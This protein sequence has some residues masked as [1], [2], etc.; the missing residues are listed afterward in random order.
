MFD[1]EEEVY[2]KHCYNKMSQEKGYQQS[3][4]TTSIKGSGEE[5]CPRCKGKVFEAE[6]MKTRKFLFHKNCFS[7][8]NCKHHL[9]YSTLHESKDGEAYC[10]MCYINIFFTSGKNSFMEPKSIPAMEGDQACIRCNCKVFDTEKVMS[11]H[12]IYHLA[13]L[14]C[15]NCATSLSQA[16]FYAGPEKGIYCRNCYD[17]I[18][19]RRARSRSRGPLNLT[20]FQAEENDENRCMGCGGKI[21]EAEKFATCFGA[22]H[23]PCFRCSKCSK[24]LHTSAE[25]ACSRNGQV[26]CRQCYGREKSKSVVA[27]NDENLIYAKSISESHIIQAE[28]GDPFGC[29]RCAGKVFEAE[30]MKMKNGCYHKKCFTCIECHRPMD[31]SLAVDGPEEVYCS[32]C[33]QRNFGPQSFKPDI[34]ALYKTEV[35][36]PTDG[37]GCPNCGGSVYDAEKLA[38]SNGVNYHK[39]CAK[40]TGCKKNLDTRSLS[41]GADGKIYCSGCYA[42]KFGGAS[43]RGAMTQNWV[44]DSQLLT[45]FKI[46]PVNG[47]KRCKERVFELERVSC[48]IGI[49]HK[50][51]FYCNG[52]RTSLSPSTVMSYKSPDNQ[53]Y[54]KLCYMEAFGEG[55]LALNFTETSQVKASSGEDACS[56]CTGILYEAERIRISEKLMFHRSC[57]TCAGCLGSLDALK[58]YIGP[59]QEVYCKYCYK[60]LLESDRSFTPVP[61][62]IIKATPDDAQGCP[63]C[64]GKVFEAEKVPTKLRWFHKSCFSCKICHHK[65]DQSSYNEGPNSEIFCKNC[66]TRE[67]NSNVSNR[68]T[69]KK[70][71]KAVPGDKDACLGCLNKVFLVD[72]IVVSSGVYHKYCLSCYSCSTAVNQLSMITGPDS[73]LFCKSCYSNLYGVRGRSGS[74][75]KSSNNVTLADENDPNRCPRCGGKVY[76]AERVNTSNG[77]YHKECFT[78]YG[79]ERNI[80]QK[81][82]NAGQDGEIYCN[83]CYSEEF[84]ARSRRPKSRTR[85]RPESRNGIR[86]RSNSV[87]NLNDEQG[88]RIMTQ[89]G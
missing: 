5:S 6:K 41:E 18:H 16:N 57:F 45:P 63:K 19:G 32:P 66:Y 30:K 2:C 43:Y 34:E 20:Q 40:C 7:C 69:E 31:Y 13:C 49:W 83:N 75:G 53:V 65:L 50:Y 8:K 88:H 23:A 74:V 1:C 39:K 35:I 76:E 14:S 86:S 64:G 12:G 56:R 73:K 78:C 24:S 46:D 10:K 77:P 9:D 79:C 44:D 52:C 81:T 87:I 85:L 15:S 84:G 25:S 58:V 27:E 28:Y 54:C 70:G 3:V 59:L 67:F 62:D 42:R 36:K 47:C 82:C 29:P 4:D 22:Y 60:L 48:E 51:C 68:F 11:S 71:V 89:V 72:K 80:N 55:I 37:S 17:S 61:T 21:F 38:T 26:L 33:F